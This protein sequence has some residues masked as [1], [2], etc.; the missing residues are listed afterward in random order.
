MERNQEKKNKAS[1]R[2]KIIKIKEEINEIDQK[3]QKKINETGADSL[4]R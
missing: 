2:K 4:K 1:R 3:K